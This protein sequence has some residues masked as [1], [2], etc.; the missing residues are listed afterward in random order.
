MADAERAISTVI[1]TKNEVER[2]KR[3][4]RAVEPVSDEVLVVDAGSRDGTVALNNV[5]GSYI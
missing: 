4:V 3:C 5:I 2:L 1:I